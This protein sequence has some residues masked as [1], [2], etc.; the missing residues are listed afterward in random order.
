[1]SLA[2][3]E[4][5]YIDNVGST[6]G[7]LHNAEIYLVPIADSFENVF[8]ADGASFVYHIEFLLYANGEKFQ[9]N[10]AEAVQVPYHISLITRMEVRDRV[11]RFSIGE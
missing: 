2:G 7:V 1:M 9:A 4:R 8:V 11:C 6:L 10:E 5:S 3:S